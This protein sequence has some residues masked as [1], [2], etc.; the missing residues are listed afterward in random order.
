MLHSTPSRR[1]LRS[2]LL[3]LALGWFPPSATGAAAPWPAPGMAGELPGSQPIIRTVP[4]VTD[5]HRPSLTLHL[6]VAPSPIA[7]GDTAAITL[8][9]INGAPRSS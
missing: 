6:D 2:M 5:P 8:T 4:P 1:L 3:V 7:V 9:V